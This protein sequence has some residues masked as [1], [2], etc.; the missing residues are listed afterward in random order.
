[1]EIEDGTV[2]W[3]NFNK[4]ILTENC[5]ELMENRL[6]SSGI[7]SQDVR[8]WKSSEKSRETCK[9][10][11]IEPEN[12]QDSIIF[13]SMFNDSDWTRRGNS[14]QCFFTEQVWT[15]FG[16][17]SEK[18]WYGK[19]DDPPEGKWQDTANMMVEQFKESGQPSIQRCFSAGS[20]NPEEEEQQGDQTLQCGCFEH[21]TFI[22][23]NSFCKLAQ[24]LRSSRK[25][26]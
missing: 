24:Y 8:H 22:S 9:K 19:S 3:K 5:L 2:K 13:M 14:E 1:M 15:F 23:N 6:S 7:F 17:G 4:L 11:N 25:M 20:W 26:V 10:Q 21:R 12:F 18:K 16:S